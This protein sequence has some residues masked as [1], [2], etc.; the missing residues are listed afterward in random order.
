MPVWAALAAI[1][2]TETSAVT[3]I[4]APGMLFA[5]NGNFWFLQFALG[6]I[7]ARFILAMFFLPRFFEKELVTIYQFLGRR[8][9]STVQKAGGGFFFVTRAMAAGVRHFAA[10]AVIDAMTGVGVAWAIV[11]TGVVSVIYTALGGLAAVIWTEVIQF[12]VMLL[13]VVI[14][15][16]YLCVEVD[17]GL[18]AIWAVGMEEG[19]LALFQW[20][21]TGR[22]FWAGLL[23]GFCLNLATHGADQDLMQRL[24]SCRGLNSARWAIV[25]SGFVVF[26]QFA[27]LMFVGLM[28][29]VF[30][31]G[32]P[33]G[34]ARAD[35]VLPHFAVHDMP[36]VAGALLLA[37]ILS[38]A[39]SSTA[40]AL[41]SL[42]STSVTDFAFP[43]FGA[44]LSPE[45]WVT[46]SRGFTLAWM[47]VLIVI[48]LLASTFDENI[49]ELALSVPSYTY[50]SLLAAFLLG[51]FTPIRNQIAVVIGMFVGVLAV[52]VISRLGLHWTWY[53]PVGAASSMV[54]AF[55]LAAMMPREIAPQ[56]RKDNNA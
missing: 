45:Q 42:S 40:S 30:Y 2:A 15:F 3:F 33:E 54:A 29:Y 1:V 5:E 44:T 46:V 27:F 10:A 7:V 52:I 19:K 56:N 11:L 55:V 51:I 20:D 4:G 50:G 47:A 14:V 22:G 18:G 12:G 35:Y 37:A 43:R 48:A 36:P 21:L 25:L 34:V 31:G 39:L 13:G 26:V 17:G 53:V 41:N 16:I 9:G 8:F 23:G 6:Y 32:L 49:L 24:L 38:A 28:L